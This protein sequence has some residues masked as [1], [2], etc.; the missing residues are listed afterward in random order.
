VT[1]VSGKSTIISL[2]CAFHHP[3][4]GLVLVEG[5][6]LSTVRLNSFRSQLGVVLQ[7]SFLFDG[8]IPRVDEFAE[9]FPEGYNTIVERNESAPGLKIETLME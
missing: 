5:V 6:D 2:V 8:T 4:T 1:R 7:E 9:R 3:D